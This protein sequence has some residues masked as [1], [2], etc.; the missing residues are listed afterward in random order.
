MRT[1]HPAIRKLFTQPVALAATEDFLIGDQRWAEVTQTMVKLPLR[2]ASVN[3]NLLAAYFLT[4]N[5]F[6]S[7]MASSCRSACRTNE[8]LGPLVWFDGCNPRSSLNAI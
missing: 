8:G 5:D 3:R 6:S 1:C 2:F 7:E 4:E